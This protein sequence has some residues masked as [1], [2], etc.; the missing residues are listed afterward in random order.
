MKRRV[1]FFL[2]LTAD[3]PLAQMRSA[4]RNKLNTYAPFSKDI[5]LVASEEN[6]EIH[7]CGQFRFSLPQDAS[8]I[9]DWIKNQWENGPYADYILWGSRIAIHDCSHDEDSPTRCVENEIMVK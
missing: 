9:R 2:K 1:R 7:V 8:E 3:A 5:D 4:I 6:G